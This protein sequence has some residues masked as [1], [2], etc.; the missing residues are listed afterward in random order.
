MQRG[1]PYESKAQNH[2]LTV[3]LNSCTIL[4]NIHTTHAAFMVRCGLERGG[5]GRTIT[6]H[7]KGK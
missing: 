6:G 7:K 4:S 1:H 5:M 2:E 3:M